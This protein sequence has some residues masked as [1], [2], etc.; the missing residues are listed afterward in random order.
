[1]GHTHGYGEGERTCRIFAC[2]GKIKVRFTSKQQSAEYGE[3]MFSLSYLPTA[4][5]LTVVVVKARKLKFEGE[6][7]DVFVKV[8]NFARRWRKEL[9][10]YFAGVPVA[11]WEKNSQEEDLD[12]EGRKVPHI[13]RGDDV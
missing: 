13:Q 4:E 3:L 8:L 1:M 12:E 2:R 11:V 5:R 9:N 10:D 7:G 6:L